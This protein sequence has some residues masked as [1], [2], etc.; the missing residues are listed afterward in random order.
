MLPLPS[1]RTRC[2]PRRGWDTFVAAG[3]RHDTG[4]IRG[5]GCYADIRDIRHWLVG[6]I[7]RFVRNMCTPRPC[8]ALLPPPFV[9]C[10]NCFPPRPLLFSSFLPCKSTTTSASASASSLCHEP[11][12]CSLR[13]LHSRSTPRPLTASLPALPTPSCAADRKGASSSS[14]SATRRWARWADSRTPRPSGTRA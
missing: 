12:L 2:K 4:H 9:L 14:T 8:P 5:W 3:A 1:C 7:E 13:V 11:A 6:V 10:Y